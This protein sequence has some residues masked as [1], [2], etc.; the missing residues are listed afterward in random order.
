MVAQDVTFA[1]KEILKMISTV[2][3]KKDVS[4]RFTANRLVEA[5]CGRGK[6]KTTCEQLK[7]MSA[8]K[9]QRIITDMIIKDYLK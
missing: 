2:E 3:A 4:D 1:C 9:I 6:S 5:C 8:L 7:K